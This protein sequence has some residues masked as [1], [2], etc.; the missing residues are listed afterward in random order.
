MENLSAYDKI[1][2]A[3]IQ[4]QDDKTGKPFF[5]YLL[6]YLKCIET[7]QVPSMAVDMNGNLYYNKIWVSGLSEKEVEGVLVHE[8]L[9]IVLQHL[10]RLGGRDGKLFN[11]CNDL[12]V[13]DMLV[14]ENMKL[15][16]GLVPTYDHKFK[17][18]EY[19]Y[20]VE[21]INEKTSEELYSELYRL[22]KK[23]NQNSQSSGGKTIVS[24][25]DL[26]GNKRFDE[27]RYG[28][29]EAEGQ[30]KDGKKEK[31]KGGVGR[32][33]SDEEI[34]KL[35]E[36]WKDRLASASVYAKQRGLLPAGMERFV[37][38][39]LDGKV[40]W[41][42]KLYKYITAELPFDFSWQKPHKKSQSVGVYLPSVLKEKIEMVVAVDTSG[43]IGQEELT[44][45]LGEICN[46]A[47]SFNNIE[48][49][50]II[51]D[52]K[53]QNEYDITNGNIDEI[54]KLKCGGG[55]GT[56]HEFVRTFIEE[57]KPNCRLLISLTDG[58]SDIQ[59]EFPKL[60]HNCHKII[61]LTQNGVS[62]KRL[63]DY[64]EVIK[65]E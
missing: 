38:K 60:P 26:L 3:K 42:H 11:C 4:L 24:L 2:R 15:P 47:C 52:A 41:R 22:M 18:E 14:S 7:D 27:H 58:W 10:L 61:V 45:F 31:G 13:N 25:G 49:K 9:H 20:E 50:L 46:I 21:K 53:L 34:K 35:E 37:D 63:E 57:K 51:G 17:I 16:E 32:K 1:M 65:M 44:Q 23:G 43:S 40:S 28:D 56:S 8:V 54:M 62:E 19:D 33:L 39:I 5:S 6:M 12:I 30:G 29:G 55:G 48:M 64:G 36:V 59:N